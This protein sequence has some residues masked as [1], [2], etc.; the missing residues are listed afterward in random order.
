[1]RRRKSRRSLTESRIYQ[2]NN[3]LY[4]F[5]ATPLVNPV[6]KKAAKWHSLCRVDEGEARARQLAQEIIAYNTGG[7]KLG[8]LASH[9]TA[10]MER[11]IKKRDKETPRDPL[12]LRMH[13]A[14]NRDR[15]WRAKVIADGLGAHDVDTIEPHELADFLD[16]WEGQKM[17]VVLRGDLNNFFKRAVRL[18]LRQ[19]NPVLNLTVEKPEKRKVLISDAQF[20]AIR[21]ALL[22]GKDG[23]RTPSGQ[24]VQCYIDL[25][26]MIFQRTTEIRLLRKDAIRDGMIHFTPTKTEKLTGTS[27]A[28]PITPAIQEVLN[29]AKRCYKVTSMYVIHRSDGKPFQATG[30]RSAWDRAGERAGVEGLTLKDI[31]SMAITR[32]KKLGHDL[33][34]LAVAAAH[35][36]EKT[37]QGYIREEDVP[38]STVV[39]PLPPKPSDEA[40]RAQ[41]AH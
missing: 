9:I 3:R 22:I 23:K 40:E 10:Y 11:E 6:T 25:C 33:K 14:G 38:I 39:L 36:D 5:A 20:H 32:A 35:S 12:K 28:V 31:R 16:Q 34:S 26:Y 4:L 1:M 15:R 19:D 2:K 27:V 8:N 41:V 13:E 37:T 30:L 24:M 29:R 21:E 7:A 18:G 17:A